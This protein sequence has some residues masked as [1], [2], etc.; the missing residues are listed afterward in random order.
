MEHTLSTCT[1]K[2]FTERYEK[3][4]LNFDFTIQRDGGQWE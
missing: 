1:V 4:K 2:T 3:Q